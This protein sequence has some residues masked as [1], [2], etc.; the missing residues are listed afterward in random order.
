MSEV[1]PYEDVIDVEP[2]PTSPESAPMPASSP[3][4]AMPAT[5][6]PPQAHALLEMIG[7][8]LAPD[9]DESVRAQ[10]RELWVRALSMLAPA[11]FPLAGGAA[12]GG[13]LPGA[14][15]SPSTPPATGAMPTSPGAAVPSAPLPT[16]PIALAAQAIKQMTPDQLI[17]TLIQRVRA[18]LPAGTTVATPRGIQ[19]QF[20]PV[21]PPPDRR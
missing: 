5:G 6:L 15:P 11:M 12:S 2:S 17:D 13:P 20:V 4:P 3:T 14:L 9:A 7:R 1:E 18:A 21:P 16:S 8:G 10:A 19:F